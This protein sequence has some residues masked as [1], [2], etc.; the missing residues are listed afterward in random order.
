MENKNL[1][2]LTKNLQELTSI[3]EFNRSKAGQKSYYMSAESF[4]DKIDRKTS[5]FLSDWENKS[6]LSWNYAESKAYKQLKTE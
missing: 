3:E 6:W 4:H 2:I 5:V 1:P